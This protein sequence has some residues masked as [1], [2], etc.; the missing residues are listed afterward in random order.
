M[1]QRTFYRK[2]TGVPYCMVSRGGGRNELVSQDG[3]EHTIS[4]DDAVLDSEFSL[5]APGMPV[6]VGPGVGGGGWV[7]RLEDRGGAGKDLVKARAGLIPGVGQ[8]EG[9]RMKGVGLISDRCSICGGTDC[10]HIS[11]EPDW[12]RVVWVQRKD[13]GAWDV[14]F[15]D[16]S[17]CEVWCEDGGAGPIISPYRRDRGGV[18]HEQ[19]RIRARDAVRGCIEGDSLWV[20]EAGMGMLSIVGAPADSVGRVKGEDGCN[21]G[22]VKGGCVR[23]GGSD[24]GVGGAVIKVRAFYEEAVASAD[25]G[26]AL[27]GESPWGGLGVPRDVAEGGSPTEHTARAALGSEGK[28]TLLEPPVCPFGCKAKVVGAGG[29]LKYWWWRCTAC[30]KEF[31]V[32]VGKGGRLILFNEPWERKEDGSW[33]PVE[34]E[35][36]DTPNVKAGSNMDTNLANPPGWLKPKYLVEGVVTEHD[37]YDWVV[38]LGDASMVKVWLDEDLDREIEAG[39]YKVDSWPKGADVEERV[40]A[41]AIEAVVA[42]RADRPYVQLV[43][44]NREGFSQEWKVLFPEGALVTVARGPDGPTDGLFVNMEDIE[45]CSAVED[46]ED[47]FERVRDRALAA[48]AQWIVK[49]DSFD[50]GVDSGLEFGEPPV[51]MASVADFKAWYEEEKRKEREAEHERREAEEITKLE[52]WYS[53]GLPRE[54]HHAY[55]KDGVIVADENGVELA[56]G[57]DYLIKYTG[58][59]F[60]LYPGNEYRLFLSPTCQQVKSGAWVHVVRNG[61]VLAKVQVPIANPY[62]VKVVPIDPPQVSEVFQGGGGCTGSEDGKGGLSDWSAFQDWHVRFWDKTQV[63]VREQRNKEKPE[64]HVAC[65]PLGGPGVMSEEPGNEGIDLDMYGPP[66]VACVKAEIDWLRENVKVNKR[67]HKF[68]VRLAF[69]KSGY[70][71]YDFQWDGA[72]WACI[73]KDPDEDKSGWEDRATEILKR[74]LR[75]RYRVDHASISKAGEPID[76]VVWTDLGPFDV[77]VRPTKEGGEGKL[78]F[79]VMGGAIRDLSEVDRRAVRARVQDAA[80]AFLDDSQHVEEIR[81]KLK[82]MTVEMTRQLK[83]RGEQITKAGEGEGFYPVER[84][85]DEPGEDPERFQRYR[86]AT[87]EGMIFVRAQWAKIG[88]ENRVVAYDFVEDLEGKSGMTPKDVRKRVIEALQDYFKKLHTKALQIAHDHYDAWEVE[89]AEKLGKPRCP[90]DGGACHHNCKPGECYREE[91]GMSLST[92]WDGYPIVP[93]GWVEFDLGGANVGDPDSYAIYL[94]DWRMTQGRKHD[95]V[96][97]KKEGRWKLAVDPTVRETLKSKDAHL[98]ICH[99][100]EGS[101]E[102]QVWDTRWDE[103]ME[104]V[105][106]EVE[107]PPQVADKIRDGSLSRVSMAEH[108]MPHDSGVLSECKCQRPKL[109]RAYDP[110]GKH[111]DTDSPSPPDWMKLRKDVDVNVGLTISRI[112]TMKAD[113]TAPTLNGLESRIENLEKAIAQLDSKAFGR[114]ESVAQMDSRVRRTEKGMEAHEEWLQGLEH[115]FAVASLPDPSKAAQALLKTVL[116]QVKELS[117]CSDAHKDLGS[118]LSK[119]MGEVLP[120]IEAIAEKLMEVEKLAHEMTWMVEDVRPASHRHERMLVDMN[121]MV[122]KLIEIVV[123]DGQLK[124]I[125]EQPHSRNLVKKV[126]DLFHWTN[127]LSRKAG[128]YEARLMELARRIGWK[129]NPIPSMFTLEGEPIKELLEVGTRVGFSGNSTMRGVV[130]GKREGPTGPERLVEWQ[131]MNGPAKGWHSLSDLYDLDGSDDE[132]DRLT[133]KKLHSLDPESFQLDW[134]PLKDRKPGE[135]NAN[136][137]IFPGGEAQKLADVADSLRGYF[138]SS[139]QTEKFMGPSM[140]KLD[141]LGIRIEEALSRSKVVV[142]AG[143]ALVMLKELSGHQSVLLGKRKGA[144]G[145]GQWSFPGGRLD[146]GEDPRD[147]AVRELEEETGLSI[148][149][150]RLLVWEHCPFNATI[151]GGQPWVTLF[152]WV[153]W[154]D[155]GIPRVMEPSKCSEW[156]FFSVENLPE[157]MFEAAADMAE[158]SGWKRPHMLKPPT[159]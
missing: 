110:E 76:L 128:E 13:T 113:Q 22:N 23:C 75:E 69:G 71:T 130:I 18:V 38:G 49:H 158:K 63:W 138:H 133:H 21:Q 11:G 41:R 145:E 117:S 39:D 26:A 114:M 25:V 108:T 123:W 136:G 153:Q 5:E 105:Q 4:I 142:P 40:A 19:A 54:H 17:F 67:G 72:G 116:E 88:D 78:E 135:P 45:N 70:H 118:A 101:D 33:A 30:G 103:P 156:D 141:E 47:E 85:V 134:K 74:W 91:Q 95:C 82:D 66:A 131:D 37:G 93:K 7:T 43:A 65:W 73:A 137:D 14:V 154:N 140:Y 102:R 50:K 129:L 55:S 97:V 122:A 31:R 155:D 86:V 83:E 52:G 147:C 15:R 35:S 149:R 29:G 32:E 81:D 61:D 10:E 34:E 12:L 112:H 98:M 60:R 6:D 139:K 104:K 80:R 125:A 157:P 89:Q 64:P 68:E 143:V 119:K 20:D 46:D 9:S 92:P 79:H 48:V 27:R 36:V 127:D 146:I 151:T 57:T 90:H 109:D 1:D 144:H 84:A 58:E 106:V 24:D 2:A 62:G 87:E 126:N 42:F 124:D 96:F 111:V 150:H 53:F 99:V 28:L 152:F 94:N 51:R 59:K 121:W 107:V 77:T 148:S 132:V 8:V 3:H 159:P 44:I 56:Q 16:G 115:R 120:R 100:Q